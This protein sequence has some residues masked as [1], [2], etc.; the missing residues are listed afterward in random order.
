LSKKASLKGAQ[1]ARGKRKTLGIMG[2]TSR[3]RRGPLAHLRRTGQ[4]IN[5]KGD[6]VH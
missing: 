2:G 6:V 1:G 3:L 5:T 4:N